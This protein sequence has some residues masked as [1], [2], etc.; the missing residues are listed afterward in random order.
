MQLKIPNKLHVYN[1]HH[2]LKHTFKFTL[3]SKFHP[4]LDTPMILALL[5]EDR[6]SYLHL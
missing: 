2:M 4:R 5:A 1:K 6:L 3:I